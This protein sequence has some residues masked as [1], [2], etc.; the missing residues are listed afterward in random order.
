MM[1]VK[2]NNSINGKPILFSDHF[3]IDKEKLEKLG[4][5]NPILNFDTKLFVEPLLLKSSKSQIIQESYQTFIKFFED[6]MILIKLSKS[7]SE[8]DIHWRTAKKNI[9]FPE[10]KSTCIGY[11]INSTSGSGSSRK[12]NEKILKNAKDII[13]SGTEYPQMFTI[14]PFLE[15]GIGG[16]II[17]DMTLKIIN[18]DICRYTKDIMD[19]L[20]LKGN[21][22]YKTERGIKY[23]FLFNPFSKCE[24][25]FLPL[26]I[27]TNL[28]MADDFDNWIVKIAETN[29]YVRG[30]VNQIIGDAWLKKNKSDK[31]EDILNILQ[32]D[33]EFFLEIVKII[34]TENFDHYNLKEDHQGIYRWLEDAKIVTKENSIKIPTVLPNDQGLLRNA[35]LSIISNF[36]NLIEND[37]IWRIFLTKRNGKK[38]NVNEFYSQM[39]FYASCQMWLDGQNSN[40]NIIKEFS[41]EDHQLYAIFTCEKKNKILVQIKHASNNALYK[42]YDRQIEIAKKKK[43]PA[44]YV[45]MNFKEEN[46]N[47]YNSIK[48]IEDPNCKII[49][50]DA[51]EPDNLPK[52]ELD[53]LKIN[54][55]SLKIDLPDIFIDFEDMPND[56]SLYIQEKRK[57]GLNSNKKHKP[58]KNKVEELCNEELKKGGYKSAL[59]LCEVVSYFIEENHLELLDDF[60]PYQKHSEDGGGWIRPTF[61]DWCNKI[62][63][64]SKIYDL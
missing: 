20:G 21:F 46:S 48:K 12:L 39:F 58:L 18:N 2:E 13:E 59:K 15:E 34:T 44:F 50:I 27:L 16:D 32:T 63:K 6:L 19:Q 17:S 52:I 30:Q 11:G 43:I 8:D 36:K 1:G 14:L 31:K 9:K 22:Q 62:F 47:Q 45:V 24:I 35:V 33:K 40:I 7:Y 53:E 61:Y 5:F 57:G 23:D 37:D 25:K 3:N 64:Q 41:S 42:I 60:E 26:D 49:K 54:I 28:P 55:D 56:Q 10:Y 29:S 51:I 38:Y 4:A